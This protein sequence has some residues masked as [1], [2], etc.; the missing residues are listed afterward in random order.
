MN[1]FDWLLEISYNKRDWNSFTETEK[2]SFNPWMIHR[3][4][5]MYYGYT[6]LA[7]TAQKLPLTEK[8]KIYNI[9]KT[10]LPKKKMY[11]KYIKGENKT[12]QPLIDY[13]S[14]YFEC[15]NSKALSYLPIMKKDEIKTM[16]EDMGVDDKE[17][18]KLIK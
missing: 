16:L 17:I 2:E 11:F 8:E 3:Y 4:V 9:Y 15:G 5:S 14:Q 12:N 13:I 18:K 6:E 7:N 1:L 10:L